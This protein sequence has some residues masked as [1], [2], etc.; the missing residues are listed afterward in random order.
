M[1]KGLRNYCDAL[2]KKS[3]TI[4]KGEVNYLNV[5]D[6]IAECRDLWNCIDEK[7]ENKIDTRD[8][9]LAKRDAALKR[10]RLRG[11]DIDGEEYIYWKRMLLKYDHLEEATAKRLYLD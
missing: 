7:L 4:K 6:T 3:E 2:L 1:I 11:Y 8:E 9:I 5:W 10:A